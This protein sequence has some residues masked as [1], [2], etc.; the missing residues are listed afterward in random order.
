[1]IVGL[2]WIIVGRIFRLCDRNSFAFVGLDH[3]GLS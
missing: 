1:M 2:R 3:G